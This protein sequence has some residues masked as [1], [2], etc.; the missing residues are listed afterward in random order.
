MSRDPCE[1]CGLDCA[2]D[3][4]VNQL[5]ERLCC[6]APED[7]AEKNDRQ[8]RCGYACKPKI[9]FT[10]EDNKHHQNTKHGEQNKEH[11]SGGRNSVRRSRRISPRRMR[12]E[13]RKYEPQADCCGGRPAPIAKQTGQQFFKPPYPVHNEP[14]WIPNKVRSICTPRITRIPTNKIRSLSFGTTRRMRAPIMAPTTD[15]NATGPATS[16]IMFPR[17]K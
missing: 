1:C 16:V 15:P 14:R 4:R 3:H 8:D 5:P 11:D 10:K 2:L 12:P 6:R 9:A 13:Q 7:D 17:R